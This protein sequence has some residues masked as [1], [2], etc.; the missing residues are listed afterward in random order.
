MSNAFKGRKAGEA[1][2]LSCGCTEVVKREILRAGVGKVG[3]SP[4]QHSKNWP[5]LGTDFFVPSSLSRAGTQHSV[6][7]HHDYLIWLNGL[8]TAMDSNCI[9]S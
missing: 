6:R 4:V 9:P 3:H 2:K 5:A 7:M 1:E 8:P